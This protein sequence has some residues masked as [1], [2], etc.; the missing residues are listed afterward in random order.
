MFK[1]IEEMGSTT[2]FLFKVIKLIPKPPFRF[3]LMIKQFEFTAYQSTGIIFLTA[4]FMGMVFSLHSSYAFG[5]FGAEALVGPSVVLALTREISGVF[6]GLM[7]AGRV[8]SAFAA[9]LGTMR[10]TE[11]IDALHAM[12]VNPLHYLVVPRLVS[13]VIASPLLYIIFTG[14]GILGGV[15]VAATASDIPPSLFLRD[16]QNFVDLEDLFIGLL[17]ASIFGLSIATISCYFGFNVKG[18]AEEVGK[19]STKSIVAN[20]VAILILNYIISSLFFAK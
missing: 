18:G 15:F 16:V 8:G 12:G 17:K 2:L 20:S 13:L 1:L 5:L 3:R 19:A 10:V 9:E 4:L 14:V 7:V 11:Q 6:T